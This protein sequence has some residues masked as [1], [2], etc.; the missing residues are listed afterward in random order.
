MA[1]GFQ[2]PSFVKVSIQTC[3]ERHPDQPDSEGFW[4]RHWHGLWKEQTTEP[5][6]LPRMHLFAYLQEPMYWAAGKMINK[7]ASFQRNLED[8]FQD[9]PSHLQKV[10]KKFDPNAGNLKSFAGV[11]FLNSL[12]ED[13]RRKGEAALCTTWA[14]LRKVGSKR[15][16]EALQQ[17]GLSKESL[18][19]GS[20][21]IQARHAQM[22]PGL[23]NKD[24]IERVDRETPQ[25]ISKSQVL[26][27]LSVLFSGNQSFF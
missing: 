1:I 2:M 24:Q 19:E 10:L 15:F 16:A 7:Y 13:V 26:D 18:T 27:P 11:T 5:A 17:G 21:T 12:R 9:S 8:Y 23:I 25:S 20:A 4:V 14:L 6:G 22:H 3:L